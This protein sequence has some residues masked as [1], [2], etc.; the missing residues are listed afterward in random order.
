VRA[1]GALEECPGVD[2][3][4]IGVIGHG[5]GGTNALLL[6]SAD[7]RIRAVVASCAFVPFAKD[8]KV[9]R[10]VDDDGLALAPK[11]KAAVA[12]D[13]YPFDWHH[14][15]S[16]IAPNPTLILTAQ[17]DE[18]LS[19]SKHCKESVITAAGVYELLGSADALNEYRHKEGHRM[20]FELVERAIAWFDQWL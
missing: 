15:L 19:G 8:P 20:T 18:V 17:N 5:L 12:K 10:W 16:M 4:R 6:A 7:E 3:D 11:L 14:V 13:E 1:I 9:G 2:P